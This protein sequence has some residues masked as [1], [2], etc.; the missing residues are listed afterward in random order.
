MASTVKYLE[1]YMFVYVLIVTI[2]Y[3]PLFDIRV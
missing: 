3:L 1:E 2:I